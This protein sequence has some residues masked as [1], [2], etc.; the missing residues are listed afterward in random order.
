MWDEIRGY[1]LAIGLMAIATGV[2]YL[3]RDYFAK[4]Q[5]ALLYLLIIGLIAGLRGV[6]PA[7]LAAILAFLAWDF[8]FLPPYH[9]FRISDPKDWIALIAFL[10]VGIAMGLQT[11]RMRDREAVALSRER[12]MALLNRF[13][14]Q[15]VSEIAVEEMA[16][17]LSAEI[18]RVIGAGSVALFLADPAKGLAPVFTPTSSSAE[19]SEAIERVAAWAHREVKAVGLPRPRGPA[20][21]GGGWP[22]TVAPELTGIVGAPAGVWV[23]LLSTTGQEGVLYVGERSD[24]QPYADHQARLLVATANQAAAFLERKRLH[25]LA[26]RADALQE[27]D[28]LKSTLLSSVS[29]ELKTP[30]S[31]MTATVSG[32]LEN[33]VDWDTHAVRYDLVSLQGDLD[34]LNASIGSLVD[35]SRLESDAWAPAKDWFELGEILATTMTRVPRDQRERIT[36]DLAEDLPTVHV[37]FTQWVRALQHIIE[38]AL[39]YGGVDGTVRISARADNE[40][41]TIAIEDQGPG[42]RPDER[43]RIFEKFYRGEASSR[44][45]SGTGLGLAIAREI[46]R[47][48]GGR[49]HV[50]DVSPHGARFVII[51]PREDP[52]EEDRVGG[53]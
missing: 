14:A 5:W 23:P 15:L 22:I 21:T 47:F 25:T 42:I 12:E 2:F 45:P 51:L 39:A 26:V 44:V 10:I 53:A 30:L 11:G 41:V 50:E 13:S 31:S 9:T 1:L 19:G 43:E 29:H 17:S 27:A 37:D 20:E 48:H 32:L 35:L 16:A 8:F 6:R 24:G 40:K 49:I 18:G 36:F 46:V 7:M 34:R 52:P 28:H 4:G 38:N 33:D 3:V